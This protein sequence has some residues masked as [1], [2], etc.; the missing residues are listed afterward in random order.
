MS[1]MLGRVDA[2]VAAQTIGAV[3]ELPDSMGL[4]SLRHLGWPMGQLISTGVRLNLMSLE[5]LAAAKRLGAEICLATADH[6][7]PLFEAAER[8]GG[9]VR[10]I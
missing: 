5:A 8:R 6:N 9:P 4:V 10:L 3:I 7:R 2:L 1:R